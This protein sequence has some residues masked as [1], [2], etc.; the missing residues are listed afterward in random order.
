MSQPIR[1]LIAEYYRQLSRQ[2]VAEDR[3]RLTRDAIAETTQLLQSSDLIPSQGVARYRP[4]AGA[5]GVSDPTGR[6][7]ET[8]GRELAHYRNEI[9]RL[10]L[11][12]CSLLNEVYEIRLQTAGMAKAISLLNDELR[13]VIEGMFSAK[14]SVVML[15]E[16]LCK[17]ES[18]IRYHLAEAYR[19]IGRYLRVFDALPDP[20]SE[21][22]VGG[23]F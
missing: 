21:Q 22:P 16:Q 12:E 23:L 3:L 13:Q 6:A 15:S 5:T 14:K 10:R 17:D 19:M 20:Q 2:A 7:A 8:Y 18:T 11:R 4:F 1:N 9:K